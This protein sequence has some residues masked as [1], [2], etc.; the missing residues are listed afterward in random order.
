M[1]GIAYVHRFVGSGRASQDL[2]HFHR[3]GDGWGDDGIRAYRAV[4]HLHRN[5]SRTGLLRHGP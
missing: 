5:I 2:G 3:V 1:K 4:G